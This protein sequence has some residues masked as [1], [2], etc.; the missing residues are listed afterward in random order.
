VGSA[1]H[2]SSARGSD[3]DI[4]VVCKKDGLEAVQSAVCEQEMDA[5]RGPV[6]R[7][8][9]LTVVS[10][11]QTQKL[12]E[13]GS[14]FAFALCRGRVLDDDGYLSSLVARYP[15]VPGRKYALTTLYQSIMVP[16]YGSFRSLHR[17]AQTHNCS[18]ECCK[19]RRSGCQGFASTDVPASVI[20]R[21]LYV[22]LPLRGFMP[23]TKEDVI[24]FAGLVYGEESAEAV[25][26]VVSMARTDGKRIYY[27]DYQQFKRLAG[28]LYREI[29][30]AVGID[31]GV[32]RMLHDGAS[33]VQGKYGQLKNSEL[34]RCV[35]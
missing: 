21:M 25:R 3:I 4:V 23:L 22:T 32:S 9:D 7:V 30:S 16:Y 5:L 8:L 33:M 1:A 15:R 17:N 31:S 12:F 11:S 29:L 2:G 24:A 35:Q 28:M 14:P 34:R 20:M 18:P 13:L 6:D 10:P 27:Y 19:E 26:S